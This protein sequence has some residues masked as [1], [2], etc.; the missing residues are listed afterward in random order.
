MAA[1]SKIKWTYHTFNPWRV[2]GNSARVVASESMWRQPLDWDRKAKKEF[3]FYNCGGGSEKPPYVRPRVFCASLADVFEDWSGNFP[4]NPPGV[5]GGVRCMVDSAGDRLCTKGDKWSKQWPDEAGWRPL[6]MHDVRERLFRLI[7]ATPNLDWLLLTKRPENIAKMMPEWCDSKQSDPTGIAKLQG[8]NNVWIGTSVEDQKTADERIPHLLKV[9]AKVR[10]LSME[11]LLGPVFLG[12]LVHRHD[13]YSPEYFQVEQMG[14]I[15]I[16]WVIVGGESGH[17]S[18]PMHPDWPRSIRDQCQAAGVPFFF[19]Q[20]GDWFPSSQE[21][22]DATKPMT[23]KPEIYLNSKTGRI[24]KTA[25]GFERGCPCD[26]GPNDASMVKIGKK[27]AGRL[28]DG[29]EWNEVPK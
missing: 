9:P 22:E 6:T 17:G 7:D 28:L 20:W 23:G 12:R 26:H 19:K 15:A 16:H 14:R 27:P 25:S 10:F 29:Q 21:D 1:N 5:H 2:R 4:D 3:D 24:A 18:R 13:G 8:R 11:P